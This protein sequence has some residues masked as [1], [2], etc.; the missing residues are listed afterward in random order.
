MTAPWSVLEIEPTEDKREVKRAYARKLKRTRPDEDSA[1]FQELHEAYKFACYLA[2]NGLAIQSDDEEEEESLQSSDAVTF[3]EESSDDQPHEAPEPEV[4]PPNFQYLL[5]H[6][7]ALLGAGQEHY[8]VENWKIFERDEHLMTDAFRISLG[9]AVFARVIAHWKAC[10]QQRN[11][12]GMLRPAVLHYLDSIFGWSNRYYDLL[13]GYDYRAED[14][15]FLN[16]L[17]DYVPQRASNR[18]GLKGG[19]ALHIEEKK[20]SAAELFDGE[21]ESLPF[22]RGLAFLADIVLLALVLYPLDY[23]SKFSAQYDWAF[24]I[25]GLY[26]FFAPLFEF[27]SWCATPGK[28]LLGLLALNKQRERLSLA[29]AYFRA[30]VLGAMVGGVVYIDNLVPFGFSIVAVGL[31]VF[32]VYLNKSKGRFLNDAASHSLVVLARKPGF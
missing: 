17:K 25:F 19:A 9:D 2:E 5:D 6:M 11:E 7:D 22:L 21:E 20:K 29:H 23:F 16:D 10:E 13:Y 14:L 28:R 31:G 15:E 8:F 27:S 32:G 24:V 4:P 12:P 26:L 1:A 18:F 30:I 3:Q